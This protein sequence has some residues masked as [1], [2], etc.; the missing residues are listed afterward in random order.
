MET[1]IAAAAAA[2]VISSAFSL[3]LL[4][5]WLAQRRRHILA[6]LVS[7]VIFAGASAALWVG[8][9]FGWTVTSFKLFYLLGA[10][11]SVPPLGLGTI[12]LLGKQQLSNKL[13]VGVA[14]FSVFSIGVLTAEPADASAWLEVGII[15]KGADVFGGVPRVLAALGSTAGSLAVLGGVAYSLWRLRGRGERKRGAGAAAGADSNID[16]T[17]SSATGNSASPTPRRIAGGTSLIALGTIM[18]GTGGLLNSVANEMAAF[19]MS[20]A[21]GSGLLFAGFLVSTAG[22]ATK[23]VSKP[24]TKPA[25]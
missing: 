7:M 14:V 1:E 16:S 20:L 3:A 18:L 24:A 12:Y 22:P 4:D 11:L 9:S 10:I 8:A 5:R 15:P 13:A 17:T 25:D 23:P 6:W 2:T 19:A 21:V